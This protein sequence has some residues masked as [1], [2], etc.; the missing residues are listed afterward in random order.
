MRRRIICL[1]IISQHEKFHLLT[2]KILSSGRNIVAVAV[3]VLG[4]KSNHVGFVCWLINGGSNAYEER[5]A[6][7]RYIACVL[8]DAA[9]KFGRIGEPY[10]A[11]DSHLVA[12]FPPNEVVETK[13]TKVD[14]A[15]QIP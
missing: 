10:A 8:D 14:Y 7:S 4:L 9:W 6:S 13:S 5:Q 1:K 3:A 15:R 2:L 11:I 12:K